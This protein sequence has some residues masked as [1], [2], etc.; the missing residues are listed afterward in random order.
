MFFLTKKPTESSNKTNVLGSG[1][2][3]LALATISTGL[4]SIQKPWPSV[5]TKELVRIVVTSSE[6]SV[7]LLFSEGFIRKLP[8]K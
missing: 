1:T 4:I 5:C 6:V 3:V 8:V 7:V 2:G